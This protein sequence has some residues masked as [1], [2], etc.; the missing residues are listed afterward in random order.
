MLGS[1]AFTAGVMGLAGGVHCVAMC[2]APSAAVIRIHRTDGDCT[3]QANG[4]FNARLGRALGFHAGRATAYALL[5][6]LAAAS[7]QGLG[8]LTTQT[9]ALRPVWTLMHLSV[10]AWGVMLLVLA[11]QP[12]WAN[13]AGRTLWDGLRARVGSAP[14]PLVAGLSWGLMPCGLLYSALL[15]AALAGG[16]TEGAISMLMFAAG[17]AVS[18]GVSPWL[19]QRL[20]RQQWLARE[21]LGVRVAGAL[22]I[23]VAAAALWMDLGVRYAAWCASS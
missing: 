5:G 22:L 6:A 7:M 1:A 15:V 21:G 23:A 2:A 13:A 19:W 17:S 3:A 10:L 14:A 11:R 8:W 9:A 4:R 12:A 16:A 18:L 20:K